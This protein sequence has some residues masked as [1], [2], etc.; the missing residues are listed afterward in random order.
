MWRDAKQY[1]AVISPEFLL[2]RGIM[3]RFS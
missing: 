2:L 3:G 1:K